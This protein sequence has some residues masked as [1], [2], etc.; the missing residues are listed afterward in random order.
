MV[1]KQD[2]RPS[3]TLLITLL[4]NANMGMRY[5]KG[6]LPGMCCVYVHVFV[7]TARNKRDL[8]KGK[9]IPTSRIK[10][11]LSTSNQLGPC[12]TVSRTTP[13]QP[14]P[15]DPSCTRKLPY[16]A[17]EKISYHCFIMDR[18]LFLP[19]RISH[20]QPT[21]NS[22]WKEKSVLSCATPFY[23]RKSM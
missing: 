2:Q 4:T 12:T 13:W 6:H 23:L 21:I 1:A 15:A 20:H 10:I 16:I 11:F 14:K 8:S 18:L 5:A 3:L 7:H 19:P 17:H 22:M 9:V